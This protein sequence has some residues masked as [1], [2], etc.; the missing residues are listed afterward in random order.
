MT[1]AAASASAA[2]HEASFATQC[3]VC[4]ADADGC[5]CCADVSVEPKARVPDGS[6]ARVPSWPVRPGFGTVS[7]RGKMASMVGKSRAAPAALSHRPLIDCHQHCQANDAE[8]LENLH[9]IN[10]ACGVIH[11]VLLAL[12]QPGSDVSDVQR[13]NRWV[14]DAS[15]RYGSHFIPF[16]TVIED[17]PG[18]AAMLESAI[19]QGARGLKLIGW[20]G[21]FIKQFDYDLRSEVME[22]VFC[23]AEARHVP[24][25]AHVWIGCQHAPHRDYVADLDAI[26]SGHPSLRLILAHYGLGFDAAS[27]PRLSDLLT[28]HANLYLDT[29]LYGGARAKWLGRA[30]EHSTALRALVREHPSQ[31]CFGS[32]VFGQRYLSSQS[33]EDALRTSYAMVAADEVRAR[34]G[35]FPTAPQKF[36]AEAGWGS[37]T[38]DARA[39]RGLGLGELNP[40][41]LGKVGASNAARLLGLSLSRPL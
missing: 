32:D 23:V 30:S 37:T 33:Y 10:V 4:D 34:P 19:E 7:L 29:S 39:M 5:A 16:V 14:L 20:A 25:L 31:I 3:E 41:L 15:R 35:E 13:R 38:F 21:T 11:A 8:G 22:R 40:E 6:K 12:R 36:D 27:L 26:M 9:R 17:D 18:A 28:R 24:I 1:E 2:A